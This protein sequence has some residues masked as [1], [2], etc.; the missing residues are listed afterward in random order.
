MKSLQDALYNWLSIKVVS[1]ARQD[2]QAAK[3]T[4][5]MF[6][7]VL[8]ADFQVTALQ[9]D[10]EEEVYMVHY[11]TKNRTGS[12]RFPREL[13]DCMLQSINENPERYKNYT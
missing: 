11:T 4:V 1:D 12:Q 13:I 5:D 6:W 8:Q 2:D 9:V 3:E 7:N 10:E